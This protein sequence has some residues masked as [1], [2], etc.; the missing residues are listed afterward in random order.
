MTEGVKVAVGGLVAEGVK[1]KVGG[2]NGVTEAVGVTVAVPVAVSVG[3]KV[4]VAVTIP[5]VGLGPSVPMLVGEGMKIINV[6]DGTGV[7][8]AVGVGVAGSGLKRKA[9]QPRQ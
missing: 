2:R 6:L 9:T 5:G 1:V 4:N 3:V 8:L 7:M